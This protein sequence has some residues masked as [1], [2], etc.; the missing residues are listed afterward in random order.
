MRGRGVIFGLALSVLGGCQKE[1]FSPIDA[2]GLNASSQVLRRF[3][4]Q[5]I[6]DGVKTMTV[7]GAE[8]RLIDAQQATAVTQ[9]VVTF[10][11]A[12]K[13]SSV[14]NA[15]QGRVLMETHEVQ[16][17]GGVTVVSA[18]SS[19]LTTDRLRYE[20]VKKL[21]LSDDDVRLEKPDSITD[22][23][24]LEATPDLA[25]VKIGHEKVRLKKNS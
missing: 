22:G 5:D 3:Q 4:M 15:P 14:M 25:R 19:T 17:W 6:Q 9:P 10:F 16:A 1:P 13:L 20:P 2:D 23:H 11:K 7:D 21:L 18:D 24:G 8:G 12:G